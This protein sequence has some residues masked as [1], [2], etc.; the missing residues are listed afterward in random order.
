MVLAARRPHKHRHTLDWILHPSLSCTTLL[1]LSALLSSA[2]RA[3]AEASVSPPPSPQ[4]R[5]AASPSFPCNSRIH[6]IVRRVALAPAYD[7]CGN[8]RLPFATSSHDVSPHHIVHPSSMPSR[9][10]M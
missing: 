7:L 5:G 8:A 4:Q 1:F 2:P 9:G 6:C 3:C 10:I